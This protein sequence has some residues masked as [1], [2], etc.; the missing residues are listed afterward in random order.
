M[1]NLIGFRTDYEYGYG[2]YTGVTNSVEKIVAT[3]DSEN[4]ARVYIKKSKLKNATT[5]TERPFRKNSLLC[6]FQDAEVKEVVKDDSPPH[7]PTLREGKR[8]I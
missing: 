2:G 6:Y 5:W 8:K 4:D 1:F 7:N 3:F